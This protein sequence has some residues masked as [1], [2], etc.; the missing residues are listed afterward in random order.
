MKGSGFPFLIR[1]LK[2]KK[3]HYSH[4]IIHDKIDKLQNQFCFF[5][6]HKKTKHVKKSKWI[7]ENAKYFIR[8]KTMAILIPGKVA[9]EQGIFHYQDEEETSQVYNQLLMATCEFK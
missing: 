4:P 9:R 3:H 1:M 7:P 8:D 2:G 6:D 5:K